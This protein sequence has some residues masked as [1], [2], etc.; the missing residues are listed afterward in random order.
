[1]PP[2]EIADPTGEPFRLVSAP[3]A[4]GDP[5]GD[6]VARHTRGTW[7]FVRVLGCP[8]QLADDLVQ[9]ALLAA[10]HKGIDRLPDADAAPWLRAAVRNLWRMHLRTQRRRPAHVELDGD[11]D[12]DDVDRAVAE[13]AL[14]RHGGS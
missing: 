10:L 3:A 2:R 12:R 13:T 14:A 9:D 5:R 6:W 8:A 11:V 7:R 1:M 4:G